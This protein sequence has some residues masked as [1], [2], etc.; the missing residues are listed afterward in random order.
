[1]P[2]PRKEPKLNAAKSEVIEEAWL[3]QD[4]DGFEPS[5]AAVADDEI[6]IAHYV[7]EM[8]K[9]VFTNGRDPGQEL[10]FHYHTKTHPL[11]H[12][13]LFHGKEY[14]L[15]VEVI[16]HLENCA[17][18]QYGYRQ[19]PNGHPEMYVKGLKYLYSCK[20]PRKVA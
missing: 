9:I 4:P 10:M 20:S 2:R 13:T 14:D 15:P 17:E 19:G 8:K 18:K 6:V 5:K 7:P 16:E 12:Y 3:K 11:K 1:M